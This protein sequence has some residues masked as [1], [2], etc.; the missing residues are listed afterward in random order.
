MLNFSLKEIAQQQI[1]S[2]PHIAHLLREYHISQEY[3]FEKSK[4][5]VIGGH[6]TFP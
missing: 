6:L 3:S 5:E 1:Y 2:I 4:F